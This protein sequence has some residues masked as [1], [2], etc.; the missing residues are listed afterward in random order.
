VK[1]KLEGLEAVIGFET[2]N[3]Y[4]IKNSLGQV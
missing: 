1:Q 2:K 3:K 4:V